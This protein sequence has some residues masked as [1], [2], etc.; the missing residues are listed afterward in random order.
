M[1]STAGADRDKMWPATL[2]LSAFALNFAGVL[3][4]QRADQIAITH[5]S[6]SSQNDKL[7][8]ELPEPREPPAND[9]HH[10][11]SYFWSNETLQRQLRRL[12]TVVAVPTVTYDDLGDVYD[13]TRWDVFDELRGVL[14]AMFPI[15]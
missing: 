11:S 6:W 2:V 12:S 14:E 7:K 13:D 5:S 10:Q 3:G 15:T 9:G 4:T 8:C 1:R